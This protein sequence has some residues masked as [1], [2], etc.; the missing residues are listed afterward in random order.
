M[1]TSSTLDQLKPYSCR[2]LME[3]FR[4]NIMFAVWCNTHSQISL[5][6]YPFA[7]INCNALSAHVTRWRFLNCDS[8]LCTALCLCSG[9]F[10]A[11]ARGTKMF[12]KAVLYPGLLLFVHQSLSWTVKA[13]YYHHTLTR[14]TI[15][16][17]FPTPRSVS[18]T[19]D[20]LCC[21]KLDL[22]RCRR[23][24]ERDNDIINDFQLVPGVSTPPTLLPLLKSCC[25]YLES[26]LCRFYSPLR[27]C[28]S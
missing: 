14:A 16:R 24:C 8:Y 7:A 17:F 3:T 21:S 5:L 9:R 6:A 22:G 25:C 4:L 12:S 28:Y 2:N 11:E 18:Y 27:V 20:L 23:L 10:S 19:R 15:L 1:F 26:C 13:I